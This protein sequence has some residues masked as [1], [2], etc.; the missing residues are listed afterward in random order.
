MIHPP[1]DGR[2][3]R[4]SVTNTLR[5][6]LENHCGRGF[7]KWRYVMAKIKVEM[8]MI[9]LCACG[10]ELRQIAMEGTKITV[11]PCAFC[12]NEA[13]VQSYD[14]GLEYGRKSRED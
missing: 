2:T 12:L 4:G 14:K 10:M 11:T 13:K 9:V 6:A 3:W 8:E 7:A 1:A 5:S